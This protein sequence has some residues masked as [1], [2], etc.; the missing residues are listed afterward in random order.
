VTKSGSKPL[1]G[2]VLVA[3][4]GE[5]AV[6]VIRAIRE[7]GMESVAVYSEA[8]SEAPH[9]AMAD[10]AVCL[11]PA[12]VSDSYL[13]VDAILDG[14][15]QTGAEAIHPGYGL[16]SE[17]A[18]FAAAVV[19]AGLV[20]IGP[21]PS[22][23]RLMASKT[24]ARAAML[25]ANVPVVPGGSVEEA[26]SI[27]Y[28]LLVKAAAGG[29]GKGMRRVD[30]G[31]D[32]SDAVSA[33]QREASKSFGDD[34][35][36]LERC[37]EHPR[38]VEVQVMADQHGSVIHL[39]ERECSVQRR[40]QKVVEESPSVAVNSALREQMGATAVAAAQSVGYVGAG[41]V[42]FLL[43]DAGH[44]Y[45]LE[46]NTRLQVEHPV[47][48]M[49]TGL[50]LV[51]EQ[52]RVALGEPLSMTQDAFTQTGHAIECR[53]YAE[54]PETYLPQT[55]TIAVLTVPDGPGIRHDSGIETGWTVGVYYDP[56]LA[57]LCAWGR[58]RSQAIE[59]MKRALD[60]YS[61]LGVQT[62]LPLLRHVVGH[63]EFAVGNTTTSFLSQY[64]YATS[65]VPAIVYAA[66][67]LLVRHG[68]PTTAMST[69]D[70]NEWDDRYSPWDRLK[71]WRL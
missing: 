70:G 67:A 46:M 35:I 6:R 17:N 12:P 24:D 53:L 32:L 19:E 27:G 50:D 65:D 71:G 42:E 21:P 38:H 39:G 23:M 9:V 63:A 25:A 45:F 29:G 58:N 22:A 14:A 8:D 69:G 20:W 56:L 61:V 49:V 18:D 68:L 26:T 55:G 54:D 51:H 41:T 37:L 10:S 30:R 3:N 34:T 52:L 66:R 13:N 2:R 16:L 31:E 47:T 48:E 44:Y 59:R 43:D 36:F 1:F 33:C 60:E 11:G 28:P 62:N 5:I 64:P 40:H 4:R 15:R 57:K 7:M